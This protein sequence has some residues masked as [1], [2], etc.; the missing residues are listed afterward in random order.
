MGDEAVDYRR[1]IDQLRSVAVD[2][3]YQEVVIPSLWEQKTFID[4]AGEEVCGQMYTFQD[5]KERDICLIP[6]V[7]AV[8]QEQYRKEWSKSLPKPVKVFY[9]Q[10][11]YRYEKPQKGRY[12]EFTQFGVECLGDDGDPKSTQLMKWLLSKMLATVMVSGWKVVDGVE[13]GLNYYTEDGFEAE[14]VDLGAQKQVAGG[15]RYDEGVGFAIG[16]D[17]ILLARQLNGV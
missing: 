12:R 10:R 4:K 5:K 14:V 9:V 6:E 13:R 7:T 17:R 3:G 1:I 11:C 2:A 8:I 15:G 16:I